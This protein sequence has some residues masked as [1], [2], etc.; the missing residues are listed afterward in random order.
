MCK[1]QD[2]SSSLISC[3]AEIPGHHTSTAAKAANNMQLLRAASKQLASLQHI[4]LSLCTNPSTSTAS[5]PQ[6]AMSKIVKV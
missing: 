6:H 2:L 3:A 4:L 5:P 1:K